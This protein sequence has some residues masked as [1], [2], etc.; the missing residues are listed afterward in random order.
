MAV[1][2]K[3]DVLVKGNPRWYEPYD[4]G[5][6]QVTTVEIEQALDLWPLTFERRRSG[7]RWSMTQSPSH[8][9]QP[10]VSRVFQPLDSVEDHAGQKDM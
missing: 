7:A 6:D 5:E 8:E 3:L 9:V 2:A 1:V 10:S 4:G